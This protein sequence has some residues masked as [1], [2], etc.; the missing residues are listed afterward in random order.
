ML[1]ELPP[2]KLVL[3]DERTDERTNDQADNKMETATERSGHD[4]LLV[5]ASLPLAGQMHTVYLIMYLCYE[6][7]SHLP[8]N[9]I[10]L[11]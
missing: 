6:V 8:L 5:D 11:L 7:S 10:G 9:A 3:E 4:S 1:Q 2:S